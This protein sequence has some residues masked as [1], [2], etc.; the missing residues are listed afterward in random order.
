MRDFEQVDMQ[1]ACIVEQAALV[2]PFEQVI[3]AVDDQLDR[4][5]ARRPTT[6][7]SA[8]MP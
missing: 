6:V 1:R 2:Q 4:Y 3:A 7:Y 8:S 5:R